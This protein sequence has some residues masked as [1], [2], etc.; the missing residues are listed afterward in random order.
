MKDTKDTTTIDALERRPGRPAKYGSA[1]EKQRAYRD[2]RKLET[3]TLDEIF[4]HAKQQI[5]Q[6]R[7]LAEAATTRSEKTSLWIM[8]CGVRH[9]WIQISI[10]R[11]YDD[12]AADLD[13]LMEMTKDWPG[14]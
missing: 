6:N 9:F 4:E 8:S 2:R 14:D 3:L 11:N 13:L 10:G 5:L 7:K 12:F 1:A